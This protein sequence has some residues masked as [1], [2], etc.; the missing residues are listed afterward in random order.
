MSGHDQRTYVVSGAASGIGRALSLL[1]ED[2][3]SVIALDRD[4]KAL[5]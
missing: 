2:G 3:A 4:S 1:L 5:A